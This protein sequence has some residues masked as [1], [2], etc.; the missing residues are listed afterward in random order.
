MEFK[1]ENTA[2]LRNVKQD[3]QEQFKNR[4]LIAS[5]FAVNS[6]KIV[7]NQFINAQIVGRKYTAYLETG[8]KG[9]PK[10]V[11]T[12]FI[13]G[14]I[15][16]MAS[17]GIAP[18]RNGEVLP[19]TSTNIKRSAFGIARGI[20]SRGTSI[21][22]GRQGLEIEVAIQKNMTPYLESIGANYVATFKDKLKIKK[23]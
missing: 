6:L 18:M 11:S 14:I 17:R 16:W 10:N 20:V 19:S 9:K 15:A 21:N 4:D 22:Q 23:S 1:Q 5:G 8:F 7:A 13:N 2:F 12:S 3:I